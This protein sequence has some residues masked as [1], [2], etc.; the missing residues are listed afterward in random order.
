MEEEYDDYEVESDS[1]L[2]EALNF[3][4]KRSKNEDKRY[5]VI[6]ILRQAAHSDTI[7]LADVITLEKLLDFS[8]RGYILKHTGNYLPGI[9]DEVNTISDVNKYI[10]KQ[11]G[12]DLKR[13]SKYPK[14][15]YSIIR[16]VISN[17][18]A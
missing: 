11:I 7:C 13:N 4:L 17:S 8:I 14:I 12:I 9:E 16:C 2:C 10:R 6:E 1:P 18:K 3:Y 5:K 15:T